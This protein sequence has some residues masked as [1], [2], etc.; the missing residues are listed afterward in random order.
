MEQQSQLSPHLMKRVILNDTKLSTTDGLS[1][2]Q[3]PKP[4]QVNN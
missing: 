1:S 4:N 3:Q 2:L